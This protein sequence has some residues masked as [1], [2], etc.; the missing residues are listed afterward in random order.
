MASERALLYLATVKSGYRA[1]IFAESIGE[2]VGYRSLVKVLP[3]RSHNLDRLPE[4]CVMAEITTQDQKD[5]MMKREKKGKWKAEDAGDQGGDEGPVRKE[6]L[7]ASAIK[8]YGGGRH[9][10][11]DGKTQEVHGASGAGGHPKP[12]AHAIVWWRT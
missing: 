6:K 12:H 11:A 4:S 5:W 3:A 9:S 7:M 10:Y 1:S 8:A 2:S